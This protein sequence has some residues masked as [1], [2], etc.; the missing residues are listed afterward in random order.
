MLGDF[1][2]AAGGRLDLLAE[3]MIQ[4]Q[5]AFPNG[6]G[7]LDR[8]ASV[9]ASSNPRPAASCAVSAEAKVQPVP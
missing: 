1:V 5:T 7:F 9:A 8:F 6:I 2:D 3:E 4:R